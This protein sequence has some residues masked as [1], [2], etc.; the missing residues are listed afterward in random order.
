MVFPHITQIQEVIEEDEGHVLPA[1]SLRGLKRNMDN[2][3]KCSLKHLCKVLTEVDAEMVLGLVQKY[4]K[5]GIFHKKK[6][7]DA[8]SESTP[9][10]GSGEEERLPVL[11]VDSLCRTARPRRTP[12]LQE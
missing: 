9:V 12:C 5:H 11:A 1:N 3:Q 4:R 6:K 8:I 2:Y 7:K 10:Y